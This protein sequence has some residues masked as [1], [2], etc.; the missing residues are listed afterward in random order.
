MTTPLTPEQQQALDEMRT[1]IIIQLDCGMSQQ[2]IV[3]QLVRDGW[4]QSEAQAAVQRIA[5]EL[6]DKD[7]A[8]QELQQTAAQQAQENA[9]QYDPNN[10]D[11]LRQI[12]RNNARDAAVRRM[13]IGAAWAIGGTLV[14]VITFAAAQ[15]GG[16]YIVAW[17]AIV[18]GAIDFLRGLVA[19]FT[20]D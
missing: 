18:F 16:T 4:L 1:N 14:T 5:A 9:P 2:E 3:A 13:W 6:P 20:A 11:R 7:S 8:F 17:G 10:I 12:A 19:Y 15:G